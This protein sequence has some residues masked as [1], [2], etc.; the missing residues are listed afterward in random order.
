MTICYPRSITLFTCLLLAL[1]GSF[2]RTHAQV[3]F[4]GTL[5]RTL[6]LAPGASVLIDLPV[7]NQGTEAAVAELRA[8]AS[9]SIIPPGDYLLESAS[10]CPLPSLSVFDSPATFLL[11]PGEL[12]ACAY[13]VSRRESAASDTRFT[14]YVRPHASWGPDHVRSVAV[15]DLVELRSGFTPIGVPRFSNGGWLQTGEWRVQNLG[16]SELWWVEYGTC[17]LDLQVQVAATGPECEISESAPCFTGM[18][19]TGLRVS[20]LAV[21][22]TISCR[23]EVRARTENFELV[24]P[25]L[26]AIKPSGGSAAL[27]DPAAGSLLLGGGTAPPAVAVP[28]VGDWSLAA[29]VLLLLA[30]LGMRSRLH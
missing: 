4:E 9:P 2:G 1:A 10:T 11:Q 20:P 13:R 28:A 30:A 7:R 16:P 25:L 18:Q 21:G 6:S 12:R 22:Q 29:L 8:S 17:D 3:A 14:F 26:G 19:P 27:I 24:L 23:V 15:G 5:P